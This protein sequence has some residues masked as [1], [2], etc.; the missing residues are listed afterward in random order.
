MEPYRYRHV[1]FINLTTQQTESILENACLIRYLSID[2][3]G[4]AYFLESAL[5]TNPTI[6]ASTSSS[7]TVMTTT[8]TTS[9]LPTNLKELRCV[10]YQFECSQR[11]DKL[12]DP[13]VN[14]L[15]LIE[16]NPNLSSLIID[17]T[18]RYIDHCFLSDKILESIS[19]H[20]NLT[21]IQWKRYEATSKDLVQFLIHCPKSLRDLEI[22]GCYVPWKPS[23]WS[24]SGDKAN[25]LGDRKLGF[26]LRRLSL[27]GDVNDEANLFLFPLLRNSPDLEELLLPKIDDFSVRGLIDT[28]HQ[29]CT[30][31]R[32]I[33]FNN[34]ECPGI[35]YTGLWGTA[36]S[37]LILPDLPMPGAGDD[38]K[39]SEIIDGSRSDQLVLR[40]SSLR[41][42]H[43]SLCRDVDNI[44]YKIILG[45]GSIAAL[46]PSEL[47]VLHLKDG[48]LN[49]STLPAQIVGHCPHMRDLYIEGGFD[50]GWDAAASISR[51]GVDL[52]T[53]VEQ[54]WVCTKI[55]SLKLDIDGKLRL[56]QGSTDR[57]QGAKNGAG[58]EL[59]LM[60]FADMLRQLHQKLCSLKSLQKLELVWVNLD[61]LYYTPVEVLLSMMNSLGGDTEASLERSQRVKVTKSDL[62]WMGL[63]WWPTTSQ[64]DEYRYLKTK[65]PIALKLHQGLNK[66]DD[67]TVDEYYINEGIPAEKQDRAEYYESWDGLIDP[68][69]HCDEDDEW[70]DKSWYSN[71][72]TYLRS[73]KSHQR[74]VARIK[75]KK[76]M[77]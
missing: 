31:L 13:A 56:P 38:T 26:S 10:D 66:P 40:Q 9:T 48:A 7:T 42:L 5:S 19:R 4:A 18:W 61:D 64:L 35:G 34:S 65:Y 47:Q 20:S 30:K 21:H 50:I 25:S 49:S 1:D 46:G 27:E 28:L 60:T 63:E 17:A 41:E 37:H 33:N 32:M 55:E 62:A 39:L 2:L 23:D 70:L 11:I 52:Q 58:C 69:F 67:N 6:T 51:M 29:H 54:N 68:W 12:I 44:L 15:S 36:A 3:M 72:K 8:T 16:W 73:G 71:R 14:A 24:E 53:L 76:A 45:L 77:F 43:M 75:S 59:R 57:H 74:K 22:S